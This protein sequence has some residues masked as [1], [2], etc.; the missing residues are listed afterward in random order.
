MV[1]P[2]KMLMSTRKRVMSMAMRPATISGGM[3]KEAQETATKRPE[4]K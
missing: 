3:R 1:I 2:K 4:G